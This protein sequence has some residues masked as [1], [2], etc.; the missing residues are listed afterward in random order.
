MTRRPMAGTVAS[1][2]AGS[3]SWGPTSGEPP[4]EPA[5]DS[6]ARS[7]SRR[8]LVQ[9]GA[10]RHESTVTAGRE[11]ISRA[12]R[13]ARG[14][15]LAISGDPRRS[16]ARS[17]RAGCDVRQHVA[18]LAPRWSSGRRDGPLGTRGPRDAGPAGPRARAGG[19][20]NPKGSTG[21]PG[22]RRDASFGDVRV[23]GSATSTR[24]PP[25]TRSS[26]PTSASRATTT[27]SPTSRWTER[28]RAST[29][30][31]PRCRRSTPSC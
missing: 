30:R 21:R 23:R 27:G 20:S 16:R 5:V 9:P 6:R 31:A 28:A 4:R 3:D 24:R 11:G 18:A 19:D 2:P 25:A 8:I 22:E 29:R 1:A 10:R 15:T 12:P 26:P 14:L 17:R 13:G 7:R